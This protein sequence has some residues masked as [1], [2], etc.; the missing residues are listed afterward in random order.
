MGGHNG[1][2]HKHQAQHMPKALKAEDHG[3]SAA[4]DQ[5]SW[6]FSGG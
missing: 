3:G 2:I 5:D 4:W 6:D 1:L